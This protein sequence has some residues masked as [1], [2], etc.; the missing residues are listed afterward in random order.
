L[1]RLDLTRSNPE[2]KPLTQGTL[3]I[4]WPDVSPDGQWIAA[5]EGSEG[6]SQLFKV[7]VAGG[8]LVRLGEG[9][10]PVW[11]PDGH[12]LAFVSSRSGSR[13]VWITSADGEWPEE[14]K[15]SIVG[16]L[17][18]QWLP[19][20][21]L[22]WIVAE[23]G[24]YQILDLTTGQK[25]FLLHDSALGG[26]IFWPR[27]SPARDHVV[28]WWNR[29]PQGQ[30]RHLWLLSWPSREERPLGG[31]TDMDPLLPDGW[32]ADGEWIYAH[33]LGRTIVR[34]SVRTGKLERVGE[35]PL[36]RIE[37]CSLTPDRKAVICSL[38]ENKADAWLMQDF[39]P[40]I[41]NEKPES[42]KR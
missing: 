25:E 34:V 41:R 38:V 2:P 29:S 27:F 5:A 21:R 39:D 22:A 8:E 19:D 12:R 7:P 4:T 20:G 36:G 18:P 32:S 23:H 14:V 6:D 17:P 26:L 15:D 28:V 1:W 13:R 31:P 42:P 37:G 16:N 33:T 9:S 3:Q 11:S 10:K 24:N 40:E 35:F 30:G